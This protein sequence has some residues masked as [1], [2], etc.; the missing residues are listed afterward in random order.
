MFLYVNV[1]LISE[2]KQHHAFS[3]FSGKAPRL[4]CSP[5]PHLIRETGE[6]SPSYPLITEVATLCR[7]SLLKRLDLR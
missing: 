2:P 1:L 4:G 3:R 5:F 6:E 7:D